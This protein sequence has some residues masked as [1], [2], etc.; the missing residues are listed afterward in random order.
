MRDLGIT[1][2]GALNV[3]LDGKSVNR[4]DSDKTRA[5]LVYLALEANQPQRRDFLSEMFWPGKPEGAGRD[6]LKQ[7]LSNLRKALRERNAETP[8]LLISREEVQ[9]NFGSHFW[10][11]VNEFQ[12][13]L[14]RVNNHDHPDLE[15]CQACAHWLQQATGLYQGDFLE[16][17]SLHDSPAFE[18]WILVQ[19][20]V[21]RR[22]MSGALRHLILIHEANGDIVKACECARQL[23][24]LEPWNEENHRHFMRLL[25]L[26][27]MR[28]AA[29]KEYY[30]CRHILMDELGIEP[31]QETNTLYEQIKN[32]ELE[33][34]DAKSP[35]PEPLEASDQ[36]GNEELKRPLLSR[37][38]L[39]PFFVVLLAGLG[40]LLLRGNNTDYH[41]IGDGSIPQN[42]L[43][44]LIAFFNQTDGPNWKNSNGWMSEG[45]PC[46]WYGVTCSYG[47]V[48]ELNLYANNLS[49]S[50]P[51]ELGGL[52]NLGV[53]DLHENQITQDIPPELGS[54]ADLEILDLSFNL[55]SGPIPPELGK[56]TELRELY[57]DGN[58]KLSGLIPSELGN[59]F[60]LHHLELSSYL[61]PT[62][63]SGPIPP[64]LGNL[65]QLMVLLIDDCQVSG[66]IPPE[67][68]QLTG[69]LWLALSHNRLSGT[70]PPEIGN[71]VNLDTFDIGGDDE[72]LLYGPLP[73]SMIKMT[74]LH[75]F[76][77][78]LTNFCEPPDPAFQ[79]WL[80]NIPALWRT[81]IQCAPG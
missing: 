24:T 48:V 7:A 35:L 74:K 3:L 49:G 25:A 45:S 75:S 63:L 43:E 12:E 46:E 53:L 38:K 59:L 52:T 34:V 16:Q 41:S 65:E 66:P 64:E 36:I 6:S 19:R 80:E 22:R 11:D 31:S 37:L 30:D 77:F 39:A 14:E 81:D 60:Q 56:L 78:R 67:L 29:L 23:V 18:E 51:R 40:F 76:D 47:S 62:Q 68:G 73:M 27:D 9:F 2:L 10:V 58:A 15:S 28:G 50:I 21:Y 20:E 42:E 70:M 71:L 26:H 32:G 17:F 13:L 54:L 5:L 1:L 57:L 79:M 55:L 4:F 33:T 8:F 44:V 69:L 72:D 61:G